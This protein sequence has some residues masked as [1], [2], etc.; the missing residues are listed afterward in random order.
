MA[1]L[2]SGMNLPIFQMP[3][4]NADFSINPLAYKDNGLLGAYKAQ[5][6]IQRANV[7]NILEQARQSGQPLSPEQI[8]QIS[9]ANPQAGQGLLNAQQTQAQAQQNNVLNQGQVLDNTQ[10]QQQIEQAFTVDLA[11]KLGSAPDEM[12]QQ[13]Y[14]DSLAKASL[15]GIDVSDMPPTY[16]PQIGQMLDTYAT[17][18]LQTQR[19]SMG[20]VQDRAVAEIMKNTG[21]DYTR[22]LY[23]YQSGYRTGTE[24]DENYNVVERQGAGSAFANIG[25]QKKYGE[26]FGE[27]TGKLS[28]QRSGDKPTLEREIVT[29]KNLGQAQADAQRDFPTVLSGSNELIGLLDSITS[30]PNLDN[31]LG[32]FDSL[33]P[34][35]RESS[36]DLIAKI[37]QVKGNQFLQAYQSLKGAG[38]IS[39]GEGK[40]AE[41]S[42]ARMQTAQSKKGFIQ[43]AND[44]K[45][46][47]K[48]SVEKVRQQASGNFDQYK[49]QSTTPNRDKAFRDIYKKSMGESLNDVG[50]SILKE[51]GITPSALRGM[52]DERRRQFL[53][54]IQ[55]PQG[56]VQDDTQDNDPLGIR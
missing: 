50:L 25:Q 35:L 30:D 45:S 2:T 41:A 49:N 28:G 1:R 8:A 31:V 24:L 56:L 20:G 51:E 23:D 42:I 44:F 54:D 11:Q 18:T 27:E 39:E 4:I 15:M 40:K 34:V 14:R 21:K 17:R 5:E 47:I 7:P 3:Q 52:S 22:A 48:K 36:A 38:Q 53:A 26:K 10:K 16:T 43:A 13:V 33:T 12:K 19:G 46:I 6:A 9:A 32:T 55:T 29:A 37:E